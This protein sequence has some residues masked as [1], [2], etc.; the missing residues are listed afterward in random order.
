MFVQFLNDQILNLYG[1][2]YRLGQPRLS[3]R[4]RRMFW[5]ASLVSHDPIV[6]PTVDLV[7]SPVATEV[8]DLVK[9]L[10]GEGFVELV[11]STTD[12]DDF[13]RRKRIHFQGTGLHSEWSSPKTPRVLET[14]K[15]SLN[16]RS[17][18]TTQD[19][20]D[21]W[22]ASVNSLADANGHSDPSKLPFAQ[23]QLVHARNELPT[24]PSFL[25]FLDKAIELPRRLGNHAFLWNVVESVDAFRLPAT[26]AADAAFERALAYY[27]TNSHLHEYKTNLIGHDYEVGWIDCGIRYDNPE[28]IFDLAAFTRMLHMIGLA[29]VLNPT[30]VEDLLLLKLDPLAT[31]A[32]SGV[33]LPWFSDL[34]SSTGRRDDV[35]PRIRLAAASIRD[36]P[37]AAVRGASAH[38][39]AFECLLRV[40]DMDHMTGTPSSGRSDLS[41]AATSGATTRLGGKTI[42]IGHGRS[43]IWLQ[44]RDLLT[45]RLG[46]QFEEFNRIPVAGL[47]VSERLRQMLDNSDFA[48]IILTGD[49][50]T[51]DG[52]LQA[53]QNVVHELGLF[54]G[55][56]GF[57]RAI[58]LLEEGCA[59]FSNIAGLQEI[60]FPQANIMATSEEIRRILEERL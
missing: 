15:A 39:R 22:T 55:R 51:T 43:L 31:A 26:R 25:T 38:E 29:R 53:R 23:R 12:L 56:L 34:T 7:Q 6:L 2:P 1:L 57:E 10:A 24:Q 5:S 45:H 49:D 9:G 14:V 30:N 35:L 13:L 17:I 20:F 40:A 42:F 21:Q 3:Q 50:E 59:E 16:I 19:M 11:G 37:A 44:L 36:L 46:L 60:R 58:V 54:Q 52:M 28:L 32:I 27:W 8:F 41:T 18:N 4:I 48:F 47:S 33:V